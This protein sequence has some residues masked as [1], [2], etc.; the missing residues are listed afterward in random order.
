MDKKQSNSALKP[1]LIPQLLQIPERS[2]HLPVED[3]LPDLETLTPVQGTLSVSHKGTYLAVK[4]EAKAIVTLTC[5][6]CLNQY[7][8]RLPL[9]AE[10]VIWLRETGAVTPAAKGSAEK[11]NTDK[12]AADRGIV[13]KKMADPDLDFDAEALLEVLSPTG[14]FDPAQWLYEQVCLAIPPQCLCDAACEGIKLE[15]SAIASPPLDSRWSVLEQLK[16]Q[17]QEA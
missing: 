10:E 8:H 14:S 9:N 3:Y 12:G 5:D 17:I 1:I 15:E 16:N 6:R 13:D 11:G 2:V 4:A 7:N